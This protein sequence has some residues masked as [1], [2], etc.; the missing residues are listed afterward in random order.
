MDPLMLLFLLIAG[1]TGVDSVSSVGQVSVQSGG[2]VTIPCFYEGRYESNVKYWCRGHDW[3]SCTSIVRTDFP[4]KKGEVSI[5]DDPDQRVFT[6]TMNNLQTGVS[7]YYWCCV[8]ISGASDVGEKVYLS[9][10]EGKTSVLQ[11]VANEMLSM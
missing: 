11:T 4:R 10:T 7:D 3:S 1:L 5:R 6:V 8:D 2:S 9:V